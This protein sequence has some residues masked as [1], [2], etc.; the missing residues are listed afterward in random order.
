MINKL[1]IHGPGL[2]HVICEN[3]AS[4]PLGRQIEDLAAKVRTHVSAVANG[5]QFTRCVLAFRVRH[6]ACV[7]PSAL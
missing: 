3:V 7:L 5:K 2:G 4:W 6:S 1:G